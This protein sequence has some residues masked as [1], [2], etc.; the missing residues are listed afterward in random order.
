MEISQRDTDV[1]QCLA[2]QQA[3]IAA[4]PVH[5]EKAELW[6]KLNQLEPVRPMIWIN[7]IPCSG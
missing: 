4:L 5:R 3:E 6:R 1:L 2:E 7:E